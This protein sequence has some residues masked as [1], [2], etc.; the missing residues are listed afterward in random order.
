MKYSQKNQNWF[1][2]NILIDMFYTINYP[3]SK[4]AV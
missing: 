4:F 1:G 2:N 3:A